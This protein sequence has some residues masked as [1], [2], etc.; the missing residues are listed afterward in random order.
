M[1]SAILFMFFIFLAPF[2]AVLAGF[3]TNRWIEER[4]VQP[5]PLPKARVLKGMPVPPKK[6]LE[7]IYQE[8]ANNFT[9]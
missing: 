1:I 5:K 9:H 6:T 3:A 2:F 4:A 8:W 7:E